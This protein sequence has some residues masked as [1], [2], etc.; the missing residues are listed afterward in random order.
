MQIFVDV[1]QA[2]RNIFRAR[3][4]FRNDFHLRR[5][6]QTHFFVKRGN[7][8]QVGNRVHS[9][10]VHIAY[11][12]R[13]RIFHSAFD[14][15]SRDHRGRYHKMIFH[16]S[17]RIFRKHAQACL[18]VERL[19]A[20]F[21]HPPYVAGF[22]RRIKFRFWNERRAQENVFS[23]QKFL[24]KKIFVSFHAENYSIESIFKAKKRYIYLG[25]GVK[26]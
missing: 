9:Q 22:Y 8:F 24:V 6:I 1:V 14:A 7:F 21:F 20:Q 5:I 12:V 17:H 2:R 18:F 15:I 26:I 13:L 19:F 23:V 16:I 3:L 11:R 25:F 10:N 4:F